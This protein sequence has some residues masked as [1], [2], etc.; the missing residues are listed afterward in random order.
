MYDISVRKVLSEEGTFSRHLD[1][2]RNGAMVIRGGEQIE[3]PEE[4]VGLGGK[5]Q[6]AS[7]PGAGLEVDEVRK[8]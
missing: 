8:P 1:N 3:R 4:V 6:E 5:P 7:V 2:E